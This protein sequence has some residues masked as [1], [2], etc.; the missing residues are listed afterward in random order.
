[1]FAGVLSGPAL[2]FTGALAIVAFVVVSVIIDVRS[3]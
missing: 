1:V 3:S 2:V